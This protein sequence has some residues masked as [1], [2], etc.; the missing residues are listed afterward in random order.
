[1]GG[2]F[3]SRPETTSDLSHDSLWEEI[4]MGADIPVAAASVIPGEITA[5]DLD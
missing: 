1:V 4:E 3:A 5:E 2:R